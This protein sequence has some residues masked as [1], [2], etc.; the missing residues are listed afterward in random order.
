[1]KKLEIYRENEDCVM[2]RTNQFEFSF[3]SRHSEEGLLEAL[4][5]FERYQDLSVYQIS[6]SEE[7]MAIVP[8]AFKLEDHTGIKPTVIYYCQVCAK[9]FKNNEIVYFIP[10]DNNIVCNHCASESNAEAQPRI[11]KE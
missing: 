5:F 7:L 10:I 11:Y 8:D 4:H 2:K 3:I 1:M 9:E 6:V